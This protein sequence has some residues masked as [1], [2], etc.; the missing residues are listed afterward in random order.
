MVP[1]SR[2]FALS[3]DHKPLSPKELAKFEAGRDVGTEFL[4]PIVQMKAGQVRVAF[5]L[6]IEAR[7]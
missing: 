7:E 4:E 5:S 1:Y 3:S 6:A 2:R